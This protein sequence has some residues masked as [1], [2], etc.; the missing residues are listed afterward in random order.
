V[1]AAAEE[2]IN[3]KGKLSLYRPEG[4]R[5]G[6]HRASA[7]PARHETFAGVTVDNAPIVLF[8]L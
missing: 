8:L 6:E 4:Q 2:V 3:G 5:S 1:L 7:Q